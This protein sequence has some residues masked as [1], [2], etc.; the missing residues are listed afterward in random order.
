MLIPLIILTALGF[1]V[2]IG[3]GIWW[4][5]LFGSL[6]FFVGMEDKLIGGIIAALGVFTVIRLAFIF[7]KA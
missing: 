2:T 6:A 5:V 4:T 3:S 1:A 7:V